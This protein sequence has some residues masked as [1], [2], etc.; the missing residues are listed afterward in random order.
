MTKGT[1]IFRIIVSVI[2]VLTAAWTVILSAEV[3]DLYKANKFDNF[4]GVVFAGVE[5]TNKNQDDILGDG[6][7]SYNE[8]NQVLMLNNAEIEYDHEIVYSLNEITILLTGENKFIINAGDYVPVIY[9]G[10]YLDSK[11]L[12]ITGEGSL[13]IDFQVTPDDVT[14]IYGEDVIIESDVTISVLGGAN[15]NISNGIYAESSLT[16]RNGATLTLNKGSAKYSA[17]VKVLGNCYIEKEGAL[18]ITIAGGSTD[19]CKGLSVGGSLIMWENTSVSVSVDDA[20]AVKTECVNV[21]GLISVGEN[22]TLTASSK[23]INSIECFGAMELCKGATVSASTEGEGAD[24][25]CYGTIAN[26]GATINGEFDALSGVFNKS[27]D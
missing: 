15:A 2:L 24:A 22:S 3:Y 20:I 5:V 17:G 25:I 19:T 10:N 8:I 11:D 12:I 14:V 4:Y 21:A 27:N 16:V 9:A 26:Y 6:T 7:V 18:N 23:K 13:T 1:K